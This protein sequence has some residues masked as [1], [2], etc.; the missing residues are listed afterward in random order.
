[1]TNDEIRKRELPGARGCLWQITPSELP[2][3]LRPMAL[4]L[5]DTADGLVLLQLLV[6]G[7]RRG[8]WYNRVEGFAL[9]DHRRGS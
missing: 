5:W 2:A 7:E 6:D 4:E 3:D 8:D 1:M 9:F